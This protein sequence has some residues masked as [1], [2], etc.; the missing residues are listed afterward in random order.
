MLIRVLK[1]E[2]IKM[3]HSPVWLAFLLIPIIPAFMGTFNYLNNLGMLENEWYS[4]WTQHTLF[5]CYFF[6]PVLIGIYASYLFRLEHANH[7]WNAVM[8]APVPIT[9]VFMAKLMMGWLMVMLTQIL[10]G[11]LFIISGFLAGLV[12]PIPPELPVWLLFGAL[13][14][15]VVCALQLCLSL[16]IRSFAVPVGIALMGGIAGLAL[17]SKGYGLYFPYALITLVC[18]ANDPAAPMAVGEISFLIACAAFIAGFC[19]FAITW[20]KQRD[21]VTG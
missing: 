14:G 16:V 20:L 17:L 18:G 15:M 13:G 6:L 5:A 4:L 11:L 21:V 1:A 7:N 10:I 2:M 19:L 12:G 8:T 3:R 9:P